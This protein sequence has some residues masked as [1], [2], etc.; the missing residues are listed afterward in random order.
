MTRIADKSISKKSLTSV[1][2]R[3]REK[4]SIVPAG[5]ASIDIL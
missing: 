4:E 5:K 1:A 3:F 2:I